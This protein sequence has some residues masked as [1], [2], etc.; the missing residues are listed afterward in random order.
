MLG[1]RAPTARL[2]P[3]WA[4]GPGLRPAREL[5][6]PKA[7]AMLYYP[8]I[9]LAPFDPNLPLRPLIVSLIVSLIVQRLTPMNR[10]FGAHGLS[11]L[12]TWGVAPRWH[13]S[14]LWPATGANRSRRLRAAPAPT[15]RL[16]TSPGHRPRSTPHYDHEG[17]RP[18]LCGHRL[19]GGERFV[20]RLVKF[21]AH[22]LAH[23]MLLH[24]HAIE[25]VRH[26]D[27]ALV[28]RDDDELRVRQETL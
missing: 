27:R 19:G 9:A 11:D 13:G 22:D 6:G 14:G 24:G 5:K 17:P 20:L 12:P 23:A 26:G 8:A 28:V 16:Y 21:H 3:A 15:A 10:A 1:I 7:R 2:I 18:V 4:T 25:H